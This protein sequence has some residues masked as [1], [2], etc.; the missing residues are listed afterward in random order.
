MAVGNR[1][2]VVAGLASGAIAALA[3]V[4]VMGPW[5]AAVT[6]PPPLA[7]PSAA[8]AGAT[9]AVAA[10]SPAGSEAPGAS[11]EPLDSLLE[12]PLES[13]AEQPPVDP[14][15]PCRRYYPACGKFSRPGVVA[16]EDC[17]CRPDETCSKTAATGWCVRRPRWLGPQN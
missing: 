2:V 5:G 15:P 10:P 6:A 3:A 9:V 11:L 4:Y 1:A 17:G 16:D 12:S 8:D 13:T 7:R 14:T